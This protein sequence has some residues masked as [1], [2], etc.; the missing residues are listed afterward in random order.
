MVPRY[1]GSPGALLGA[2]FAHVLRTPRAMSMGSR[3]SW[4]KLGTDGHDLRHVRASERKIWLY[5][6]GT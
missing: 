3:V 2:L 5:S 6:R 4:Y 1:L